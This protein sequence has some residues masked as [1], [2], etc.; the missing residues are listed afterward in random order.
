M[1]SK[2]PQFTDHHVGVELTGKRVNHGVGLG[3]DIPINCFFMEMQELQYGW[4]EL[5]KIR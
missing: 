3:V 1:L 5:G 2:S 4:K